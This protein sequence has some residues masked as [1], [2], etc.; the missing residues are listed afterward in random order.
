MPLV[1][2]IPGVTPQN[3]WG[4]PPPRHISFLAGTWYA[5]AIAVIEIAS[6]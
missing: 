1:L 3:L 2:L 5:L 4:A 6:A